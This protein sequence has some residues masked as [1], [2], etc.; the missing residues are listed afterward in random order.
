MFSLAPGNWVLVSVFKRN[1]ASYQAGGRVYP[2]QTEKA[3]GVRF[4]SAQYRVLSVVRLHSMR[5]K[6]F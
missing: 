6:L 1:D 3:C 2:V 4:L 5:T